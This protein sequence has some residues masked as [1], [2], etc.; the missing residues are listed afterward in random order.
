MSGVLEEH[1]L[2]GHA[3]G[4][5]RVTAGESVCFGG[6]HVHAVFNADNSPATSVHVYAPP[7]RSM[8]FYRPDDGALVLE[9]TD[10]VTGNR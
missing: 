1:T 7:L 5:R 8:G 3:D 4:Q 2:A 10:E 9:R 6:D